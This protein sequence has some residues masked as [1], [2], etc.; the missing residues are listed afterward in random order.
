MRDAFTLPAAAVLPGP[1]EVFALLGMRGPGRHGAAAVQALEALAGLVRPAGV[2][3]DLP[4]EALG[5]LLREGGCPAASPVGRVL[6]RSARA[7]LFAVTL[8][9]AAEARV[10]ELFKAGEEP[11]GLLLDAAASCAADRASRAAVERTLERWGR[12]GAAAGT[13]ALGYSPGYCG[14]PVA[15]QRA[16]FAAL[17]PSEAGVALGDSCLMAPLKSV[18]GAALSGPPAIFEDPRDYPFCEGCQH[19]DCDQRTR[20]MPVWNG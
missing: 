7:A 2:V 15:G 4:L 14:W 9:P 5:A 6:G 20:S 1:D 13:A 11:E 17:G 18:S 12:E 3:L 8:G 19:P 16:L 10:A